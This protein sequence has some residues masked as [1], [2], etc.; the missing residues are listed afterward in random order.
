MMGCRSETWLCNVRPVA[1]VLLSRDRKGKRGNGYQGASDDLR[2]P[3]ARRPA[4][5]RA[6]AD[7]AAVHLLR[8]RNTGLG[9]ES[10]YGDARRGAGVTI[11]PSTASWRASHCLT[12]PPAL[13]CELPGERRESIAASPNI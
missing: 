10:D 5:L 11:H 1:D 3:R 8:V 6:G 4:A 12:R 7:L 2:A 13:S 9:P